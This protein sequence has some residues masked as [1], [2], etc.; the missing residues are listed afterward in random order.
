MTVRIDPEDVSLLKALRRLVPG[1]S[2]VDV[3]AGHEGGFAVVSPRK[4]TLGRVIDVAWSFNITSQPQVGEPVQLGNEN[5][6]TRQRF[7]RVDW[8]ADIT[9]QLQEE[10]WCVQ[11]QPLD[12]LEYD[13][14]MPRLFVST[15]GVSPFLPPKSGPFPGVP[16]PAAWWPVSTS[17]VDVLG[18]PWWL[19]VRAG[20]EEGALQRWPIPIVGLSVA[21]RGRNVTAAIE[22]NPLFAGNG[23]VFTPLE[24]PIRTEGRGRMLLTVT[25]ASPVPRTVVDQLTRARIRIPGGTVVDATGIV[26]IPK[27]ATY[28]ETIA[29]QGGANSYF[30]LDQTGTSLGAVDTVVGRTAVPHEAVAVARVSGDY[31]PTRWPVTFQVFA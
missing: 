15:E 25:K 2:A 13:D 27:F 9:P 21:I 28:L 18:S 7:G 8:T 23:I 29:T 11:V 12:V 30:W 26:W 14:A 17:E 16:N 6:L 22:Y 10:D 31:L 24:Q 4:A 20:P 3:P 5:L 1:G 19:V